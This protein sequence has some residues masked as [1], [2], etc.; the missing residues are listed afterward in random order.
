MENIDKAKKIVPSFYEEDAVRKFMIERS[1]VLKSLLND[2]I[3]AKLSQN[4]PLIDNKLFELKRYLTINKDNTLVLDRTIHMK[5]M[6]KRRDKIEL[7][8]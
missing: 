5:K 3:I 8:T 7:N 6:K 1:K 4:Y 2:Y